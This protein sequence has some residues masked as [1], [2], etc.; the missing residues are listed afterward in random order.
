MFTWTHQGLAN[1]VIKAKQRGIDVQVVVDS[2]SAV[3]ASKKVVSIL[4]RHAVPTTLSRGNALLHHKFMYV[5]GHTLVHGSA[6]W[7]LSAFAK[8]DDCFLIMHPLTSGQ[9][10]FMDRLWSRIK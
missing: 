4:K 3:G 8:N 10:Q 5:D 9:K 1:E 2:S 7:T 6:N